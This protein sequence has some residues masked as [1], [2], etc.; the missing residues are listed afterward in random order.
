MDD[1]LKAALFTVGD[2]EVNRRMLL[3][4][5][6]ELEALLAAQTDVPHNNDEGVA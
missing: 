6:R 5:V 4:R 1:T 3:E 2:L